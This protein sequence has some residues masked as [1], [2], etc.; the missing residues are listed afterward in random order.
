MSYS[1]QWEHHGVYKKF[2][3]LVSGDELLQSVVEVAS[4]ARFSALRYEVSDYLSAT[5]TQFSQEALNEVRAVRIGSFQS[6]P[7]IKVAIV[8]LDTQ[9]ER[10]IFSTIAARLTLHQTRV[11]SEIAEANSWVGR[12]QAPF[13]A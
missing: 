1:L 6:N 5:Q 10:R 9:I 4:D 8:T 2:S 12:V 13:F 3:G 11:F 7:H